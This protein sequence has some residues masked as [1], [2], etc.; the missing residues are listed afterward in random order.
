MQRSLRFAPPERVYAVGGWAYHTLASP[1]RTVGVA[2]QMPSSCFDEKDQLNNRYFARRLH[3]LAE[4]ATVLRKNP[5]F[6][7]VSWDF[8]QHDAR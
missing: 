8:L 5:T 6:K 7:D 3:Y 4:V 2:M 1:N